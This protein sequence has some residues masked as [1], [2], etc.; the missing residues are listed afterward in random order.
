M[1]D[2]W[3]N[4]KESAKLF[5]KAVY[6]TGKT[7]DSVKKI[8][9]PALDNILVLGATAAAP[10]GAGY[11]LIN[12]GQVGA[13]VATIAAGAFGA[14][15]ATVYGMST[16]DTEKN[17][18]AH[19]PSHKPRRNIS[20][21][22]QG[23]STKLRKHPGE[24]D[25][26]RRFGRV[27]NWGVMGA[28]LVALNSGLDYNPHTPSIPCV[29]KATAPI[30]A[31]VSCAVSGLEKSIDIYN[32]LRDR[33]EAP[34]KARTAPTEERAVPTS[35]HQQLPEVGGLSYQGTR[36]GYE[37]K[38]LPIERRQP[39]MDSKAAVWQRVEGFRPVVR[40][41]LDLYNAHSVGLTENMVLASLAQESQGHLW[42]NSANGGD[43]GIIHFTGKTAEEYDL[44]IHGTTTSF[45][46]RAHGAQ[47]RE[48]AEDCNY[49]LVCMSRQDERF[50]PIK[51]IDAAV[52]KKVHEGRESTDGWTGVVRFHNPTVKNHQ[53]TYRIAVRQWYDILQDPAVHAHAEQRFQALHGET[54]DT[55]FALKDMELQ[56]WGLTTYK[57]LSNR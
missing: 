49:D 10:L 44:R 8:F 47:L 12:N 23:I 50:H 26:P 20:R 38:L 53:D 25:R 55:Y 32:T 46:D 39:A 40:A 17:L 11:H 9:E 51:N 35:L 4:F 19:D 30:S 36:S 13:G 48:M 5:G 43:A 27:A 28:A 42:L 54:I 2:I 15:A 14:G 33:E 16:S 45:L 24:T 18:A 34:S 37:A 22:T 21:F 31:P 6:F 56:N 3:D 57:T 29:P 7:A 41:A 1:S 52:R